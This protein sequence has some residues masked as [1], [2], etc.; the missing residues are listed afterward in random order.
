MPYEDPEDE[1]KKQLWHTIWACFIFWTV[2]FL[3]IV[4]VTKCGD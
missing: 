3:L 4:S 2:F 1:E